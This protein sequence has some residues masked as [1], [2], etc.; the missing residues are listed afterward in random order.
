VIVHVWREDIPRLSPEKLSIVFKSSWTIEDLK[1]SLKQI[2]GLSIHE[3]VLLFADHQLTNNIRPS[4]DELTTVLA[5]GGLTLRRRDQKCGSKRLFSKGIR[6]LSTFIARNFSGVNVNE[7]PSETLSSPPPHPLTEDTNTIASSNPVFGNNSSSVD[8]FTLDSAMTLA[9][10]VCIKGDSISSI[11]DGS[12][13]EGL[14]GAYGREAIMDRPCGTLKS[15]FEFSDE[16]G[17]ATDVDALFSGHGLDVVDELSNVNAT[18]S[19]VNDQGFSGER[20]VIAPVTIK[21]AWE[22]VDHD[23]AIRGHEF[24]DQESAKKLQ[25][26][27]SIDFSSAVSDID[28]MQAS[29]LAVGQTCLTSSSLDTQLSCRKRIRAV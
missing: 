15:V 9:S 26:I 4:K 17:V 19:M 1:Q 3:Q 21:R 12:L 10:P 5:N 22:A 6:G 16:T 27:L 2:T 23:E 29:P 18:T 25:D 14:A 8:F 28:T 11:E 24:L 7:Q 13:M 20:A